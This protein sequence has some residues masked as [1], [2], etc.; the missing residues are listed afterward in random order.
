MRM[1]VR[2]R[3]RTIAIDGDRIARDEGGRFD[4]L[5]ECRDAD[6][7]PGLINA[8]DHLHRNHYGRLGAG[9]YANAYRWGAD[10][11]VRFRRRI[12]S[13][14]RVP[15]RAALLCGAWKNLLCGVTTVVHHDPW[16]PDFER[17][18]PIRVAR[19]ASADSIGME[20]RI[21]APA[22]G[23]LCLHL[24]EGTDRSS[25]DEVRALADRDLLNERLVAVHGVGI[26]DLE[27]ERFE[28]SGAA[29][30]WCPTSNQFLFGRTACARLL[31]GGIDLLLGSDSRLTGAGDL[32]DEI[33]AARR[34]ALV[35]DERL[36]GAVGPISAARLG[37]CAPSLEP[38]ARADFILLGRSLGEA[39]SDDI[40]L[41]VVG[42]IPRV[43]RADIALQL[44]GYCEVGRTRRLG[45]LV[46]W[47]YQQG[48][49]A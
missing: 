41:T 23:P 16:E 15:R 17:D 12:A 32:L 47:T 21:E 22:D 38:G 11:H 43:A 31:E 14:R 28:R 20:E 24:A 49:L 27:I 40:A 33:R 35:D 26:R 7:H 5:V 1:L 29:L 34:S 8:H 13:G 36:R 48:R 44:G 25:S 30:A 39:R 19:V 45:R 37:L 10:I 18:F 42:G 3:N 6:L 4:V 9:P 46:R 2:A